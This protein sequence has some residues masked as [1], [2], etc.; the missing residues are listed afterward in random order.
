MLDERE[1]IQNVA[2][3]NFD[4]AQRD[5]DRI[6]ELDA[7]IKHHIKMAKL[8]EKLVR[9]EKKE[10]FMDMNGKLLAMEKEYN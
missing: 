7:E 2:Q 10:L 3:M 5:A 1:A 9:Q 6:K 4:L 8:N